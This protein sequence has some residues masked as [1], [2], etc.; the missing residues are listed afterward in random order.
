MTEKIL[1]LTV[2]YQ[3]QLTFAHPDGSYSMF[4]PNQLYQ[5]VGDESSLWLTAYV[6]KTLGQ[7]KS[8]IH[9]DESHL[10]K[11][12]DYIISQQDSWGCF[13][14]VCSSCAYL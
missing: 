10:Q 6:L 12:V 1:V 3:T 13:P 11:S 7:A 14:Q 4:G 2:G 9:I 5:N 8:H